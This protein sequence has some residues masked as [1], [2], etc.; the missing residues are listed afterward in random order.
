MI[1][2]KHD[3]KITLSR[4]RT[5]HELTQPK[6]TIL[7]SD[8]GSAVLCFARGLVFLCFIYLGRSLY[9]FV[10]ME[11]IGGEV[12]NKLA[13]GIVAAV[14][15]VCVCATRHRQVCRVSLDW[16]AHCDLKHKTRGL[17]SPVQ[18][19]RFSAAGLAR[20]CGLRHCFETRRTRVT[21]ALTKIFFCILWCD[22]LLERDEAF[23][24]R[25]WLRA[26]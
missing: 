4:F 12:A 22:S 15:E 19:P 21:L 17:N 6:I 13:V 9:S 14:G 1:S 16:R 8:L 20:V 2:V 3:N 10:C 18:V 24:G 7:F 5:T 11:R 23:P 25:T 26:V